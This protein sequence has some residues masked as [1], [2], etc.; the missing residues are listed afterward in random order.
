MELTRKDLLKLGLLGSAALLLPLERAARTRPKLRNRLPASRLP[1]PFQVAFAAPPV[2]SPV[3]SDATTDY[4]QMTM[5]S[6]GVPILP[7]MPRTEVWGYGGNSPGPTIVARRGRN[8]VVRQINR[9]SN[10]R[11]RWATVHLHGNA[12]L[13]QY[14][15]YANDTIEPGFY[16]DYRYPNEQPARTLWYHD[17]GV[18]VTAENAY[19]GLAGLYITHDEHESSLPI[20]HGKYDV[21]L[22]LRDAVFG[23][24]GQMTFDR[25]ERGSLFGDVILVNG[26]PWPAMKVERRKYRFRVLNASISRGFNLALSTGEPLTV[27]GHDGGL[28]PAPVET[29]SM[30]VGMAERYEVVIDF[31]KYKIGDKVVLQ[32][33]G[34]ENNEQY[35][36][37]RQV[38]RFDV[39]GDATKTADNTIPDDLRYDN[40]EDNEVMD[41]DESQAQPVERE[42]RFERGN[43]MWQINDGTWH[44]VEASNYR[45]VVADPE[46]NG[47]EI[48]RLYNNS[49]GWNHP[50]HIHLVDFK[51]LDR[52]GKKPF[53]YENGPKDVAYIGEGE[54]VRAIMRFKRPG[55]YMIH[56]HNLV[57]EDHDMMAQFEVGQGGPDPLSDPARPLA[58]APP[59]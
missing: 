49:G 8:T 41:L 28:A 17:H 14:D 40:P 19:M 46:L 23:K 11:H 50:A 27:I 25:E 24:D 51:I 16:K 18:H 35:A 7:G 13:P 22:V 59:L 3:R 29:G 32:N 56:C 47:V 21:P 6:A 2:L 33:R 9:I 31:E 10:P 39:V 26:R 57:H 30:R 36:S 53:P 20:P 52:D 34:L 37:T 38:M 4:Y 44:D 43:G 12:S 42:I 1:E 54:E 55:K 48:W 5:K 15:G 58:E 45:K